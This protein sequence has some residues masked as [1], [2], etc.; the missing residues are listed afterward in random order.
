LV[1]WCT[2]V[3]VAA[4][5]VALACAWAFPLKPAFAAQTAELIVDPPSGGAG[6][7]FQIVG[8]SDWTAGETVRIRVG[9]VTT[10]D[11]A[12]FAGPYAIEQDLTVLPDGTWSFPVVLSDTFFGGLAPSTPGTIVV[13]AA[14][15]SNDA[16]ATFDYTGVGPPPASDIGAA[17]FGPA[18]GA[19]PAAMIVSLFGAG[20]GTMLIVAG[21]RRRYEDAVQRLACLTPSQ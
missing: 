18:A 3:L 13:R 9:F 16:L 11:P 14:S 4:S 21:G 1:K 19:A 2:F 7:R 6:S 8:E 17:G 12:A 20:I 5:M 15:P 10:G